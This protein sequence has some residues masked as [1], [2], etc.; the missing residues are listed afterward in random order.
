M[1]N[2][3]AL[4]DA[5]LIGIR[6]QLETMKLAEANQ[7]TGK[8]FG[9]TAPE[10]LAAIATEQERRQTNAQWTNQAMSNG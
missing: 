2:L 7:V 4:S 6:Y 9:V 8:R 10:L 5:R 3:N 1:V